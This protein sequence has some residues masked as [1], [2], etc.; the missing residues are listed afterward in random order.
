LCD[1]LARAFSTPGVL[2]QGVSNE[3]IAL[4]LENRQRFAMTQGERKFYRYGNY[5]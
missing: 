5:C 2:R 1:N 3:E 4:P